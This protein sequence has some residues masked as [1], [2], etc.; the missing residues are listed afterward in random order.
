LTI[1]QIYAVVTSRSD[2]GHCPLTLKGVTWSSYTE[3]KQN[4]P[5]R[6]WVT[7]TD[8]LASLKTQFIIGFTDRH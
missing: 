5:I 2:L 4:Q 1:L 7:D 3:Y 6:S 8:G